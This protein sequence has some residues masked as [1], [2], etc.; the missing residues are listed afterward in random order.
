M[1]SGGDGYYKYF[2]GGKYTPYH[3]QQIGSWLVVAVNSEIEAG[4][5]SKQAEW[6]K[7]TLEKSDAKCKLVFQHKPRWSVGSHGSD[8]NMSTLFGIMYEGGVD[9]N[10]AGH[11]HNYQRYKP[12][13][14]R[15]NLKADGIRTWV[16]GTGGAENYPLGSSKAID[17]KFNGAIGALK[18]TLSDGWY[19][20]SFVGTRG[21]RD[22]IN[23][24]C[25]N[26]R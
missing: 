10:L 19:K 26:D 20:A 4:P 21:T 22:S 7:D 13:D 25:D 3:A 18:M 14:A 2:F 16:V 11:D 17:T 15:G 9:V 8:P 1:K 6:L 23:E 5:G 12:V 24:T